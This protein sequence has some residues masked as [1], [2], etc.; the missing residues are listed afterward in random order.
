MCSLSQRKSQGFRFR[1]V[2]FR[3]EGDR[4]SRDPPL[5]SVR[6]E[7][8]SSAKNEE[9]SAEGAEVVVRGESGDGLLL[10]PWR[11]AGRGAVLGGV[12]DPPEH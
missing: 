9:G 3:Q 7:R 11:V 5:C 10:R 1:C 2:G 12:Q 4:E 6:Y 8:R